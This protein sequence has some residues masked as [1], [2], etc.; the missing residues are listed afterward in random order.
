MGGGGAAILL[1]PISTRGRQLAGQHGDGVL[2]LRP[3][4]A[5]LR[6]LGLRARKLGLRQGDIG[7]RRDAAGVPVDGELQVL[8]VSFDGIGSTL[9]CMSCAASKK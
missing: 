8:L 3:R 9:S 5:H 7:L 4:D 2:V 6:S 1:A